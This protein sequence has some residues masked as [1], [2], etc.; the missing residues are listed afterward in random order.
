MPNM[1]CPKC[2][3]THFVAHRIK[4][5]KF[6][7]KGQELKCTV[8]VYFCKNVPLKDGEFQDGAMLRENMA[9]MEKAIKESGL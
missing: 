1:S 2:Q 3:R 7:Y 8:H 6:T 5:K 9:N 4:N